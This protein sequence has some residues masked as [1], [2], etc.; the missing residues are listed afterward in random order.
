M[1]QIN[2]FLDLKV[3]ACSQDSLGRLKALNPV[4][5]NYILY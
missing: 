2:A 1:N 4:V 3:G 5:L